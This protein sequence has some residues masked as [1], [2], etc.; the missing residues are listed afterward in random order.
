LLADTV[1]KETLRKLS[2]NTLSINK[3]KNY[4]VLGG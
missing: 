2:E 4:Q 1:T 3:I